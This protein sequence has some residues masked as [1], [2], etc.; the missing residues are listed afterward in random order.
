MLERFLFPGRDMR[1]DV[2]H[3]PRARNARLQHLRIGQ[4]CV[5]FAELAPCVIRAVSAIVLFDSQF[6]L[7]S[8]CA[9]HPVSCY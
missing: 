2:S 4:T 6:I 3:R 1:N 5:R 8:H 7:S 9:Y